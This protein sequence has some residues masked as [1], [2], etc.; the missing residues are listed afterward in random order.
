[1]RLDFQWAESEAERRKTH[2][3]DME[4]KQK[5]AIN[6]LFAE[7]RSNETF[8]AGDGLTSCNGCKK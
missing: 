4:R 8:Y 5:T 7:Q 1:V 2:A 6:S 3:T